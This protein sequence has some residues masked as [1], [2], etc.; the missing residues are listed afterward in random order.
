MDCEAEAE[1]RRNLLASLFNSA[2]CCE[3]L[4]THSSDDSVLDWRNLLA[5]LL[6]SAYFWGLLPLHTRQIFVN[7]ERIRNGKRVGAI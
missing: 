2:F 4:R 5:S 6:K 3:S 1:F 7:G